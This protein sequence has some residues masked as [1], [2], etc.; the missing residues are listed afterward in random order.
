MSNSSS[1][2]S[3]KR[4]TI[5]QIETPEGTPS[6]TKSQPKRKSLPPPF[7]PKTRPSQYILQK[8]TT[9]PPRAIGIEA[10]EC[11]NRGLWFRMLW[12]RFENGPEY[13]STWEH[14]TNVNLRHAFMFIESC[15]LER[16]QTME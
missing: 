8:S 5:L 9:S 6:P 7:V 12:V 13:Y 16:I 3:Y 15:M 1:S 4:P 14:W 2:T 11:T 10:Y